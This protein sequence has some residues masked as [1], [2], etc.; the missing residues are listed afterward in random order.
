MNEDLKALAREAVSASQASADPDYPL[1]HIVAPVGRLNDPN[2]LLIDGQEYHAFYQF[3][4]FHPHRKLVYWGHVSSTD[5]LHWQHHDPAVIPDSF[6]DRNGAYS[7]NAI[8][9]EPGELGAAPGG[10]DYQLFYTGNLKDPVTDERTASQCLVTSTDLTEFTKWPDNPLIPNHPE[11]YTAHFRD[12]QVF[13]DP[14]RPGEFR[15]LLGVQRA[16]ETG[17]ALLYRSTDLLN[18]KLEGELTF[19][20]ADG[21]FDRFG[22]MWECPGIVRLRD[23]ATGQDWDVL[24]WCPQGIDPDKEGYETIFACTYIVGHLVGTEFRDCDGTFHEVDRGFEFYAPQAFARRTTEPGAVVLVGWA[25]NAGED[26]QPSIETGGWVHALTVPRALSLRDGRL[27]QRPLPAVSQGAGALSVAGQE[28]AAGEYPIAELA[29]SRSWYLQLETA[30]ATGSWGLRIGSQDSHV[31]I[32]IEDGRLIV[33]RSTSRYTQ[34]GARR[35]VTLPE[36]C[37]SRLE[38]LHDRSITELFLGDGDLALTLRSFVDPRTC[39]ATLVVEDG[40]QL[41]SAS[42][43]T[44]D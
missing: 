29:D 39:G 19:P 38:V 37:S 44:H 26:D 11:G 14:D 7:G 43:R 42:A 1:L 28:L 25:G 31:D 23:E 27:V 8:V 15:M 36:G 2:G 24:I 17:A 33:D 12:P 35:V 6:Y 3:S 16:D 13:R 10:G 30:P 41:R 40:L 5:A 34:H 9:L 32:R 20:D 4:P 18:W 21:A 22:Y